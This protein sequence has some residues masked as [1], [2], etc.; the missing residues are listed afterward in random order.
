MHK[1]SIVTLCFVI[2]FIGKATAEK[3]AAQVLI[4]VQRKQDRL[5]GLSNHFEQK[6]FDTRLN[7]FF[8]AK[9][10]MFYQ[11]PGL[12][13]WLY[14]K[15]QGKVHYQIIVGKKKIWVV[16]YDLDNVM[17]QDVG[18]AT[19]LTSFSFLRGKGSLRKDFILLKA[20]KKNHLDSSSESVGLFLKPK[21]KDSSLVELQLRVSKKEYTI[22]QV[23][24]L[25][26]SE[27]YQKFTFSQQHHFWNKRKLKTNSN[28]HFSYKVPKG[29]E[30]IQ[31]NHAR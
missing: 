10:R 21:R 4:E 31:Q 14:E 17:I 13:K 30:V 24:I 6:T 1:V 18:K 8:K 3:N 28:F 19:N 25:D 27:S 15:K 12:L 7:R 26:Q 2:L 22:E 29:M 9:G 23:V 20:P 5:E 11:K 16:D